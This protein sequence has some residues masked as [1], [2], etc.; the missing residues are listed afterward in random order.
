VGNDIMRG[1]FSCGH[2]P[3]VYLYHGKNGMIL[4]NDTNK[5]EIKNDAE[6]LSKEIFSSD[7]ICPQVQFKDAINTK[8]IKS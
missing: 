3:G 5:E 7:W 8:V 2:T 1:M 4:V 6:E